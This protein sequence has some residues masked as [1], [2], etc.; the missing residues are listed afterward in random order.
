MN[1][2]KEDYDQKKDLA[3]NAEKALDKK[4]GQH[5]NNVIKHSKT[6]GNPNYHIRSIK[7][8][9]RTAQEKSITILE[10]SQASQRQDLLKEEPLSNI[11]IRVS[12]NPSF[13]TLYKDS[14][15]ILAKRNKTIRTNSRVVERLAFAG[16]GKNW[17]RLSPKQEIN[18]WFL[19]TNSS[20]DLWEKLDAHFNEESLNLE[21]KIEKE[22]RVIESEIESLLNITLPKKESFTRQSTLHLRSSK[23]EFEKTLKNYKKEVRKILEKLEARQE[24]IFKPRQC[25]EFKDFFRRN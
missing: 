7:E 18:L 8:D 5:A 23:N 22:I 17:S 14:A 11:G 9:I 2:K 1:Q 25:P 15:G 3:E 16:L 12:F 19:W 6:Y 4:L 13:K 21:S 10:D 20:Q 24:D